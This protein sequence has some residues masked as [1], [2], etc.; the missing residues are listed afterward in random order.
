MIENYNKWINT[1]CKT[2]AHDDDVTE[3]WWGKILF[4]C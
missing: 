4:A 1:F 2:Q 3:R